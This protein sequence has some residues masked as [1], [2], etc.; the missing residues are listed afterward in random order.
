MANGVARGTEN[1]IGS[2]QTVICNEGY[3]LEGSGTIYCFG[4]GQWTSP[5]SCVKMI[6]CG[7]L[8]PV[9]NGVISNGSNLFGSVRQI[10]C[11]QGFI[12]AGSIHIVCLQ[13]GQWT[14]PGVCLQ[15]N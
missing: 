2:R 3:R 13:T 8:P 1:V 10:S 4:G 6:T 12:L 14:S 7:D 5:G 9:A 15:S 11:D